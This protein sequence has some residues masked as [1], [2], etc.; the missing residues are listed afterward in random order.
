MSFVVDIF[1]V[2]V[3]ETGSTVLSI[4]GGVHCTRTDVVECGVDEAL[5]V[6]IVDWPCT[7]EAVVLTFDFIFFCGLG[8]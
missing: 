7:V 2:R 5:T 1:I 3:E 4:F 8:G 6:V